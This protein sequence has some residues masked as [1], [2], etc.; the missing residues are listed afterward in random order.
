MKPGTL[1]LAG[2]LLLCIA[3]EGLAKIKVPK[4]QK[5]LSFGKNKKKKKENGIVELSDEVEE[6]DVEI[7][8]DNPRSNIEAVHITLGDYFRDR[9]SENI[10]R[11]G[12]LLKNE[13]LRDSLALKLKFKRKTKLPQIVGRCR[14]KAKIQTT[15]TR[16]LT[17]R[18]PKR[19][20]CSKRKRRSTGPTK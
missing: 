18:K 9:T 11:V 6:P 20:F 8:Y 4:K 7:D 16:F 17:T 5:S 1:L 3:G 14:K 13:A 15:K 12:F 10:Y 2:A 19:T